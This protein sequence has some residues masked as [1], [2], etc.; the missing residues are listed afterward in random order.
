MDLAFLPAP[1]RYS[2]AGGTG[3]QV[4]PENQRKCTSMAVLL[5]GHWSRWDGMMLNIIKVSKL[6]SVTAHPALLQWLYISAVEE[7]VGSLVPWL[8]FS[9]HN[10]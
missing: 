3:V 10:T 4:Q 9:I 1:E 6:P 7:S 2:G 5:M 8:L